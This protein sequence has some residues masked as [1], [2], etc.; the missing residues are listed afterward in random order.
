LTPKEKQEYVEVLR[1]LLLLLVRGGPSFGT[2]ATRWFVLFCIDVYQGACWWLN[3]P[4]RA[5]TT[6]AIITFTLF[7]ILNLMKR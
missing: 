2:S 5:D 7:Q 6:M 1:P 4:Q 3:E